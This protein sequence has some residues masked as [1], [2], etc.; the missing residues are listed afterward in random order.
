MSPRAAETRWNG[1]DVLGLAGYV[2][3]WAI[4]T[5]ADEQKA[6]FLQMNRGQ[7]AKERKIACDIGL[8]RYSRFANY[9]GEWLIWTA[10]CLVGW[11][12]GVGWTRM[13]LPVCSWFVL[14]IFYRLS[15]PLAIESVRKRATDAQFKEW[16]KTS[17][18]VPMPPRN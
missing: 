4:E 8:F 11:Q 13:F 5:V 15:I 6:V 7:N 14:S 9:F 2:V 17:L 1:L 3:G 12:A 10:L 18:F 16:C